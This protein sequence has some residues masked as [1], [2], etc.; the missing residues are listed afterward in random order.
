MQINSA[1]SYFFSPK[2]G[3]L[4]LLLLLGPTWLGSVNEV[5]VNKNMALT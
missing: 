5:Q 1:S 3:Y 2:L 4:S